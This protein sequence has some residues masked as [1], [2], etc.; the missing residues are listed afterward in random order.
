[1]YHSEPDIKLNWAQFVS[2]FFTH[3]SCGYFTC[4]NIERQQFYFV[5]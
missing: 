5:A 2:D 1:M 4:L 3:I